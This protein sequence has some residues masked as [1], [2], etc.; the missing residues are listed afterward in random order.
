[1]DKSAR[2][3][4]AAAARQRLLRRGGSGACR[5]GEEVEG[6]EGAES[7]EGGRREFLVSK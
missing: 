3:G 7:G 2:A 1:M 5:W 6:A 4:A